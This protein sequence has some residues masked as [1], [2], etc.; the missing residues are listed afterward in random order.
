V[1]ADAHRDADVSEVKYVRYLALRQFSTIMQWSCN[2]SEKARSGWQPVSTETYYSVGRSMGS[3][4]SSHIPAALRCTVSSGRLSQ[5]RLARCQ[6]ES[7]PERR[8][9]CPVIVILFFF[10]VA[11]S[12]T[13][14]IHQQRGD[15]VKFI[16]FWSCFARMFSVLFPRLAQPSSGISLCSPPHDKLKDLHPVQYSSPAMCDV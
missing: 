16:F 7:F 2:F 4:S 10:V 8:H 6:V 13:G 9:V 5:L 3:H 11:M 1:D 15:C 14:S 12:L